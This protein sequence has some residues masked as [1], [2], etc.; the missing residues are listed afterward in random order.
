MD[1]KSNLF[2][3]T[4]EASYNSTSSAAD[5]LTVVSS[6]VNHTGTSVRVAAPGTVTN[7][8]VNEIIKNVPDDAVKVTI[9]AAKRAT[10]PVFSG[11][12]GSAVILTSDSGSLVTLSHA[13]SSVASTSLHPSAVSATNLPTAHPNTCCNLHLSARV[14][15]CELGAHVPPICSLV[16]NTL[17]NTVSRKCSGSNFDIHVTLTLPGVITNTVGV[18]TI[19]LAS[20]SVVVNISGTYADTLIVSPPRTAL[21]AG[22]RGV[23][24]AVGGLSSPTLAV[25]VL[26]GTS[27]DTVT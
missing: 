18:L 20:V 14:I 3:G 25:R 21:I 26:P 1:V 23:L 2:S 11:T 8:V 9:S 5:N 19:T 15:T 24:G 7:T 16:V 22:V 13:Y 10:Y 17:A 4:A 12:T 6:Y 27:N